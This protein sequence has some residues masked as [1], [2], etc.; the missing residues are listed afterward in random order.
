[1]GPTYAP[2]GLADRLATVD[3]W[4]RESPPSTRFGSGREELSSSYSDSLGDFL[5]WFQYEFDK[6]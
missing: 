5:I 4:E 2:S 1:M 3:E 6:V